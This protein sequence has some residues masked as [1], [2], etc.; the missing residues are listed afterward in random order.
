MVKRMKKKEKR[1]ERNNQYFISGAQPA[2]GRETH[3]PYHYVVHWSPPRSPPKKFWHSE[4]G[5]EGEERKKKK[6]KRE[7]E[8]EENEP[9]FTMHPKQ[10]Q[11]FIG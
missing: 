5:E 1:E 3:A 7:K 9:A 4:E 11:Y 10:T 2:G 8:E 6:G